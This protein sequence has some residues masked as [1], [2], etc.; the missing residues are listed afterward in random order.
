MRSA[1]LSGI[2]YPAILF[3]ALV[4]LLITVAT[5]IVPTFGSLVPIEHWTGMAGI[6]GS[7][8][9]FVQ[10]YFYTSLIVLAVL[11]VAFVWSLPRWSGRTRA[12]VDQYQ[13]YSTYRMLQGVSFLLA[14]SAMMRS[15]NSVTSSLERMIR[16]ANPWLRQRLRA[17]LAAYNNDS[18]LGRA[19]YNNGYNFP[20]P[21]LA[22]DIR[23]Y[24]GRTGFEDEIQELANQWVVEGVEK[25][26]TVTAVVRFA[27]IASIAGFI[28]VV[29]TGVF[30]LQTLLG[31]AAT[32]P[33][34]R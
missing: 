27:M 22:A 34:I 8:S 15:G 16:L 25:V 1:F 18:N 6:L 28:I 21:E 20:D 32:R 10:N 9:V 2:S 14:I 4:F 19:L 12:I 29:I 13:P 11:T 7:I 5:R 31:D 24:S 33:P 26:N 3:I 30:E 17:T 23:I